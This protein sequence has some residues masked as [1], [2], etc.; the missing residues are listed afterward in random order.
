MR[1]SQRH[2]KVRRYALL[3]FQRELHR[4]AFATYLKLLPVVAFAEQFFEWS[5]TGQTM[6]YPS[7]YFRCTAFRHMCQLGVFY[8]AWAVPSPP[9]VDIHKTHTRRS[10]RLYTSKI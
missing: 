7:I 5:C 10:S 2:Y 4:N 8:E 3:C 6:L 9:L 1:R